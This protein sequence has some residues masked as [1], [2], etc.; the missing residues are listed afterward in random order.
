MTERASKI[1]LVESD[2]QLVESLVALLVGRFNAHVTCVPD[3]ESGLDIDLIEPHDLVIAELHLADRSG[4]AFDLYL[5]EGFEVE[6]EFELAKQKLCWMR[7][8]V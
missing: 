5:S 7:R 4:L 6:R 1:L 8:A 3:A 2:S